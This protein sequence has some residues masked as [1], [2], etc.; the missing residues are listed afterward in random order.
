MAVILFILK[1]IGIIL[2]ILIGI[3][4]FAVLLV[5]FV[6]VHYQV[7]GQVEE[8]ITIHAKINWLLHL[9]TFCV[10]YDKDELSYQLRILG[11]AK[12][13]K[14]KSA[15]K[16]EDWENDAESE[17]DAELENDVELEEDAKLEDD[18]RQEDDSKKASA[19][20][21]AKEKPQE[22]KKNNFLDSLQSIKKNILK[23]LNNGAKVKEFVT[24]EANQTVF[25]SV[26]AELKYLLSHFRFRKIVTDLRFSTGDPATTGQALGVLCM[27]P[28]FY[29][30][31]INIVPD[32]EEE[33]SY[34]KGTFDI[35]GHM[36]GIH[37]GA[38]L[39]RL[40]KKQ[41]VQNLVKK[42]RKR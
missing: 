23:I 1:I 3:I 40:V 18:Q 16:E 32:F 37:F 21:I 34:V 25:F 19:R 30:Y 2:L 22:P 31:Q 38:S 20:Q 17:E 9:I 35:E 24:D 6:P 8:K 10:D 13:P 11:I 27:F 41:E 4:L 33:E 26:L 36:R 39:I 42:L 15:L 12:K 14:A 29:Q 28:I 7:A 5:L